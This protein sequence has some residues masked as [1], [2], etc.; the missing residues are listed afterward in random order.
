[1]DGPTAERLAEEHAE[2][3]RLNAYRPPPRLRSIGERHP[4]LDWLCWLPRADRQWYGQDHD[5]L[6]NLI[7]Y[8]PDLTEDEW[9][10][11]LS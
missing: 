3:Q 6:F 7:A 5:R 8:Y 1:M 9:Q 11:L 10:A 4:N 2:T